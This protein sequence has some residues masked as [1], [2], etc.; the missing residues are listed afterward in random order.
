MFTGIVEET[1]KVQT[2][3]DKKIIIVDD[4][5]ELMPMAM[6]KSKGNIYTMIWYDMI[7]VIKKTMGS[8]KNA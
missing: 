5:N 3:T 4:I 6:Q 8:D 1:G 2:V 7:E